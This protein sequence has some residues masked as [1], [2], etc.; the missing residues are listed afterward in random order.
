[1]SLKYEL[2]SEPLQ[3]S[4]KQLFLDRELYRTVQNSIYLIRRLIFPDLSGEIQEGGAKI[5]A[6]R[7]SLPFCEDRGPLCSQR[8]ALVVRW[9]VVALLLWC[10]GAFIALT[11][12]L[13][14]TSPGYDIH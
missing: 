10:V 8:S 6:T 3:N 12:S 7:A 14:R 9:R 5:R 4:V 13:P 1:M 11:S 2:S